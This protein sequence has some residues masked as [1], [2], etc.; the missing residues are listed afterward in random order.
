MPIRRTA[1]SNGPI[2]SRID[3][4]GVL[5][6]SYR[7]RHFSRIHL[8]DMAARASGATVGASQPYPLSRPPPHLNPPHLLASPS[9]HRVLRVPAACAN[10]SPSYPLIQTEVPH[11]WVSA[12]CMYV[13]KL[14]AP[15]G[16]MFDRRFCRANTVLG[17]RCFQAASHDSRPPTVTKPFWMCARRTVM[18]EGVG[19]SVAP[20]DAAGGAAA[21]ER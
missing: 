15:L 9:P 18:K 17:E 8:P 4:D 2:E 11:S 16:R 3:V 10:L 13:A 6:R 19:E 14:E 5:I 12:C 1:R 7:C 21:S 20:R